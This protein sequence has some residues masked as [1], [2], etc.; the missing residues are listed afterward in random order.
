M[1]TTTNLSLKKIELTDSPPDITVQDNNWDTIDKHLYTAVKYQKAGGT[2]TAI[3]LTEV[4]LT[5][6]FCKTFIAIANN[7]GTATTINGKSLYKPGSNTAPTLTTGK[8]YTIWYDATGNCFFL[9]ASASG[10]AIASNV[11]AGTNFSNDDDVDIPGTMPE[12]GTVNQSLPI[13]G[14]YTIPAGHHSGSGKVTQSI[15]TKGA[16]TITPGTADQTI[17]AGKYLTGD[18]V[19]KGDPNLIPDK[20]LEGV[21]IFGVTGT[22][23]EARLNVFA[24]NTA[25]TTFEGVWIKTA[26]AIT[27]VVNDQELWFVDAWN[28]ESLIKYAAIPYNHTYG[29]AVA[30]GTDVYVMGS[31]NTTDQLLNYKYNTLTNTWTRLADAPHGINLRCLVAIET[32]I[33]L[34][35]SGGTPNNTTVYKYDTVANTWTKI[36][37]TIPYT[38]DGGCVVAIGSDIFLMGNTTSTYMYYTYKYNTLTN[39]WTR[40]ADIPFAAYRSFAVA[41]GTDIFLMGSSQGS[42]NLNYRYNTLTNTWVQQANIPYGLIDGRTVAVGTDIYALGAN[43][44]GYQTSNYKYSTLTNT[45]TQQTNIPYNFYGGSAVYANSAIHIFGGAY[46]G[47]NT[48]YRR[49]NFTSKTYTTGTV[50]IYRTNAW[51]GAYQAEFCTPGVRF[52]GVN[53]RLLTGFDNVYMYTGGKLQENL[54]TYYGNGSAWVKFKG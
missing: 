46:T 34:V 25:P 42:T 38:F 53:N 22:A 47:T 32:D 33:Y 35:G 17:T 29:D 50:I 16:A 26:E 30:I 5:D 13:N 6:G 28:N 20:I 39:T 11:L 15:P 49:F 43:T 48:N 3:T 4:T 18:Q 45:W 36:S 21:P 41:I 51:T 23:K 37:T 7:N 40:L 19:I 1:K 14:T 44:S 9:R 31:N 10:N 52:T 24:G 8:A 2:G 12:N 27:N 54:T